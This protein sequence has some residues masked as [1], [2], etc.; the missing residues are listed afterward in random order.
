VSDS[1]QIVRLVLTKDQGRELEPLLALQRAG[2]KSAVLA[3]VSSSYEPEDGR[4]TIKL[5]IAWVGRPLAA[6]IA[7]LIRET[8]R[9]A[10]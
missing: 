2:Q 8:E 7:R 6:K 5:D 10:P 9:P 3:L 4:V 1:P